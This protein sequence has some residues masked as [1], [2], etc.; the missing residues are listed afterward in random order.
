MAAVF[1]SSM[2]YVVVSLAALLASLLTFFSG[3]GL[4]T[5][6]TPVIAIFFPIGVAIAITAVVH[7]LNNLFKL[8]LVGRHADRA[9]LLRF[10]IPAL[11]AAPLGAWLLVRLSRLPPAF[12]Y[13]L[14]GKPR[15]PHWVNLVIAVLIIAFTLFELKPEK[16]KLALPAA[17]LPWGGLLSGFFGGLSGH[18]GAFRSAFLARAGLH[19]EVFIATGVAIACL[20]DLARLAVYALA[21]ADAPTEFP[22]TIIGAA[23]LSAFLGAYVGSGVLHKLTMAAIQSAVALMLAGLAI[24]L[25]AGLL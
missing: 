6:L 22:W 4:G 15:S 11:V 3:F 21:F 16:K 24:A 25:G 14:F 12:T 18:Q 13:E 2:E 19:K 5:L 23:T 8:V 7:F 9:I 10:G 1:C 20:V 17:W